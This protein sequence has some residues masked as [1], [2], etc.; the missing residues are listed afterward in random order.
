MYL[1]I[2][3]GPI[4]QSNPWPSLF[5]PHVTFSGKQTFLRGFS[6]EEDG[7]GR[8]ALLPWESC[9]GTADFSL[10]ETSSLS[11]LPSDWVQQFTASVPGNTGFM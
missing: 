10:M 11:G 1:S 5:V 9:T 7:E 2:S 6:G 8:P 3:K 4:D